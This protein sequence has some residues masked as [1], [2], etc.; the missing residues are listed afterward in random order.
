MESFDED[1]NESDEDGEETTEMSDNELKTLQQ[2]VEDEVRFS[3]EKPLTSEERKTR[4]VNFNIANYINSLPQNTCMAKTDFDD[5]EN[6]TFEDAIDDYNSELPP[7]PNASE[8]IEPTKACKETTNT[9]VKLTETIEQSQDPVTDD[10]RFDE[11]ID[12]STSQGRFKMVEKLLSDARSHRSYS[13]TASTIAPSVI[14]DR[15]KKTVDTKEKKDLRKRC[16]AKGEASAVTRVRN[17]NRD[18]CKQYA[19]WDF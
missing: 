13:T 3:E 1:D 18:V 7:A 11:N 10:D 5:F 8:A 16:V 4:A 17:E 14:K 6:D 2:Q 15:I 19:G 9:E 12:L